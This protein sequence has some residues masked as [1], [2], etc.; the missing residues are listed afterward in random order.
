MRRQGNASTCGSGVIARIAPSAGKMSNGLSY[1]DA[2]QALPKPIFL[3]SSTGIVVDTNR[4]GL[5]MIEGSSAQVLIE[6]RGVDRRVVGMDFGASREKLLNPPALWPR[7]CRQRDESPCR[8][9]EWRPFADHSSH[10][11]PAG[12]S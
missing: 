4:A 1:I 3:V 5:K 10:L 7:D 8:A 11:M 2:V 12:S 6:P 9:A